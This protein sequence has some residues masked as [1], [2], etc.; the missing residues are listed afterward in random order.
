MQEG[1]RKEGG[2]GVA[3]SERLSGH[4]PLPPLPHIRFVHPAMLRRPLGQHLPTIISL[5][6]LK[7]VT[8]KGKQYSKT[9]TILFQSAN[10]IGGLECEMTEELKPILATIPTWQHPRTCSRVTEEGRDVHVL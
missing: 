8:H 1:G 9:E 6:Q 5:R 4:S 3:R 7:Y 10:S 2:S